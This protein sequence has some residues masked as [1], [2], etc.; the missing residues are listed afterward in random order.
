VQQEI[1]GLVWQALSKLRLGQTDDART[2]L[3]VVLPLLAKNTDHASEI[4]THSLLA[5]VCLHQGELQQAQHAAETAAEVIA[6]SASTAF[7][8]LDGYACFAEACLALWEACGNQPPVARRPFQQHA[9]QACTALRR[10]ARVLPV[11]Q[12]QAWLWQGLYA[13]LADKP[14]RAHNAW[15]KSLVAAERLAMPYEQGLAH[16]EIGRHL[17]RDDPDRQAHLTCAG[18]IFTQL[19][20]TYDLARTQKVQAGA[21]ARW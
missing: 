12:P 9:R 10:F 6:R 5:V 14:S 8:A 1:W 4:T 17:A 7:Y 18:D 21:E 20:A 2:L 11:G 3:A 19:H 13:W 16:Y 15:R